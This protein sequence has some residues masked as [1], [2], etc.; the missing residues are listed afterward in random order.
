[1]KNQNEKAQNVAQKRVYEKERHGK[2]IVLSY[3]GRPLGHFF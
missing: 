2:S 3:V 1:M